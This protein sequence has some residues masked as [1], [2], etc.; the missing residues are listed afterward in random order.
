MNTNE[1]IYETGTYR[2]NA[3]DYKLVEGNGTPKV[4][5]VY[6]KHNGKW[7]DVSNDGHNQATWD[8]I[9]KEGTKLG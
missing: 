4:Q 9:K 2:T 8:T 7:W 5:I 1:I 6:R 3:L